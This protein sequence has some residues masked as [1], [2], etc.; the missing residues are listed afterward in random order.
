[1]RDCSVSARKTGI[2]AS[3]GI[4]DGCEVELDDVV[5]GNQTFGIDADGATVRD[6]VVRILGVVEGGLI[7]IDITAGL[8]TDFI[9]QVLGEDSTGV[10]FQGNVHNT[11]VTGADFG[12]WA[13]N[14]TGVIRG[15]TAIGTKIPLRFPE[16]VTSVDNSFDRELPV[17]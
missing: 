7:G 17:Q 13:F 12:F 5:T 10:R 6:C 2:V 14:E 8:V 15:S 1:M 4:I 11:V 16:R 9:V 3:G